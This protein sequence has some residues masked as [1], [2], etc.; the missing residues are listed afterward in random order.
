MFFSN[1]LEYIRITMT[2][3]NCIW[4]RVKRQIKFSLYLLP[5]SSSLP[6]SYIRNLRLEQTRYRICLCGTSSVIVGQALRLFRLLVPHL[7]Q[8]LITNKKRFQL[9]RCSGTANWTN[10]TPTASHFIQFNSKLFSR[11]EG[12]T[13]CNHFVWERLFLTFDF[14]NFT[15]KI[16]LNNESLCIP[17]LFR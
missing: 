10:E 2:H 13:D 11:L 5:L 8:K 3:Q 15:F 7:H 1:P 14:T 16:I 6:S 9:F 12:D 17:L 4:E